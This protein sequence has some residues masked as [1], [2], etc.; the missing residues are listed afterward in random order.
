MTK[1]KV[2]LPH[3]Y[4]CSDCAIERGAKW[5]KNHVATRHDAVCP[6]CNKEKGL[7]SVTDWLW[8]GEKN[9]KT[10]D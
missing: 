7:C 8:N 10:W 3:G 9:L 4:I 6:Y 2:N 1:K 5:P